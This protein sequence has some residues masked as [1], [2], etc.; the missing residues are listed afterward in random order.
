LLIGNFEYHKSHFAFFGD[1]GEVE[2]RPV[3]DVN[4]RAYVKRHGPQK[5]DGTFGS[6]QSRWPTMVR[7]LA[8]AKLIGD[9][10]QKFMGTGVPDGWINTTFSKAIRLTPR[11]V[12]M[13]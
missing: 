12:L 2:L 4:L 13:A 11:R 10:A 9:A 6:F 7:R 8:T 3:F 5:P 1:Y